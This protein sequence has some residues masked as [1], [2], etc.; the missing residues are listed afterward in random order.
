MRSFQK[1]SDW[2]RAALCSIV[3]ALSLLSGHKETS[4]R[5]KSKGKT[6]VNPS[7]PMTFD[8]VQSR[9]GGMV[10][11]TATVPMGV[12]LS[13]AKTINAQSVR[14]GTRLRKPSRT[15]EPR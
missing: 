12:A 14:K 2:H 7:A 8:M 3:P 1:L 10:E 5:A 11:V 13:I 4:V 6:P 15:G 9:P